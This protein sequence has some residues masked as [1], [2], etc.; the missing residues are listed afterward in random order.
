MSS[1]LVAT[2]AAPRRSSRTGSI[3]VG[4]CL[5]LA[6]DPIAAQDTD[7]EIDARARRV[8]ASRQELDSLAAAAQALADSPNTPATRRDALRQH[9][10]EIRTR[11][12]DGDFRPGDRVII[13]LA[14]DSSFGDTLTVQPA[15]TLSVRRLPPIRLEGV[16]RSELHP[17]LAAQLRQYVRD[18]LVRASPLMLVGVLG[19]V[20]RPGYYRMPLEVPLGEAL[21]MAGGPTPQADLRRTSVRRGNRTVLSAPNVR[22]AMVRGAPLSELGLDA[23]DE[24]IVVG[25]RTR[26]WSL[27]LQIAG[28]ATGGVL[29]LQSLRR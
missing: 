24:L 13:S 8:M 22:E 16:L 29:A 12:R 6:F 14:R 11:L 19:E 7:F 2:K 18:S 17:Y 26:N 10:A 21:M 27:I 1:T 15:R 3:L 25:P 23:G 28:I 4:L 5:V 9:V 20:A